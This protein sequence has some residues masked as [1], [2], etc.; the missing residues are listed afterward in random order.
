[1]ALPVQ[2]K[3]IYGEHVNTPIGR[4]S[5]PHV[6]SPRENELKIDKKTGKPV[7]EY[8]ITLLFDKTADLGPLKKE[9]A[10]V[11]KLAE[12]NLTDGS[13]VV[14]CI[15]DGNVAYKK[16]PEKN[17][18]QKDKIVVIARS[19]L[20]PGLIDRDQL[21][22]LNPNE[23]YGGCYARIQVQPKTW[24]Q[25]TGHGIILDLVN[26]QKA[27]DGE[28]FGRIKPSASSSFD[29]IEPDLSETQGEAD[30]FNVFGSAEDDL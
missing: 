15:K 10:R 4:V 9:I 6:F 25:L 1:M 29:A 12:Y 18:I 26:I 8:E 24:H 14:S 30:E 17:A 2:P 3:T 13:T 20:K 16:D 19:R 27:K 23:F 7:L 28:P 21:P 22:I 5:F 11:A